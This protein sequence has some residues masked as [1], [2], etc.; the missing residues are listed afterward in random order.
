MREDLAKRL[1]ESALTQEL[2]TNLQKRLVF[3]MTE[4]SKRGPGPLDEQEV[5][6]LT[7]DSISKWIRTNAISSASRPVPA[8]A[9]PPS[10]IQ[11]QAQGP[12]A[13]YTPTYVPRPDLHKPFTLSQQQQSQSTSLEEESHADANPDSLLAQLGF[14]T[15][16]AGKDI[17]TAF[18][19]AATATATA[20]AAAAGVVSDPAAPYHRPLPGS[21]NQDRLPPPEST[22]LPPMQDL[23]VELQSISTRKPLLEPDASH[24][25]TQP[26]DFIIANPDVIKY[27]D[28]EHNLIINSFDR[29]WVHN[30]NGNRY[31][32]SVNFNGNFV[33]QGS[34]PQPTI[35]NR[36]RNIV[37]IEFV[38]ALLPVEGLEMILPHDCSGSLLTP[39]NACVSV[40]SLP[41]IQVILD[42]FDGNNIGT[43]DTVD[44]SLAIC[45]YDASW[46]TDL[47]LINRGY[48]LFFP[49]LMKAQRLYQPTPMANLQSLSFSILNPEGGLLST[50]P[51]K[52]DLARVAFSDVSDTSGSCY[53][54][55][56][57][58][59]SN[60]IF[61][62]TETWFPHWAFSPLDRIQIGAFIATIPASPGASVSFATWLNDPAGHIVIGVAQRVAAGPT[63]DGANDSGYANCIV[64]Q[65]RRTDPTV[66]GTSTPYLFTGSAITELDF[67]RSVA[68]FP[69]SYQT[70]AILNRSR[71]VQL[72]LRVITRDLD[73]TSTV[74]AD[75]V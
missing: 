34:G 57:D 39:A 27:I 64:I 43:T 1:P 9:A 52:V 61:L 70:G 73:M 48:S 12:P 42:E 7:F 69:I 6:R 51:D 55:V 54:D 26:K 56:T 15:N 5:K 29:D 74:R 13:S 65:N 10:K 45:Q 3:F 22:S 32:F 4:L 17:R 40:L 59:S 35:Q 16:T 71:Q 31:H 62:F 49:K 30:A 2:N 68:D 18:Q 75:N 33:A 23:V 19:H 21:R 50:V 41:F 60:Y 37:R 47:S 72:T 53:S 24:I 20:A 36:I 38:K 25:S 67:A 46:R 28:V 58:G 14:L 66:T 63:I 44:K 8:G 11:Q